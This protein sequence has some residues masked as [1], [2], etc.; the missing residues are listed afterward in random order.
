[1]NKHEFLV[2]NSFRLNLLSCDHGASPDGHKFKIGNEGHEK[3]T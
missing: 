1:M 3:S 2:Q